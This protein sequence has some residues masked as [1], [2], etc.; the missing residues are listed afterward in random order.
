MRRSKLRREKQRRIEDAKCEV[1]SIRS[2]L[3]KAYC[4][5][6]SSSDP[7]LI[8]ASILEISALRSRYS[9]TLRDIKKLCEA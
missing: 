3:D 1:L 4:I 6:N 2:S 9:R 8:E 7:E 5:F